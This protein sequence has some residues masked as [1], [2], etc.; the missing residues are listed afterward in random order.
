METAQNGWPVSPWRTS[1][2]CVR[3]GVKPARGAA[4]RIACSLLRRTCDCWQL[5]AATNVTPNR[6][7]TARTP[8]R[9]GFSAERRPPICRPSDGWAELSAKVG[10]EHDDQHDDDADER[11]GEHCYLERLDMRLQRG[12]LDLAVA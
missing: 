1:R 2:T 12:E 10:E 6:A 7:T 8:R 11:D 5:C 9:D 4:V 3:S